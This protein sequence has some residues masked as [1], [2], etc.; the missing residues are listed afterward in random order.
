MQDLLGYVLTCKISKEFILDSD[1]SDE[2]FTL[3]FTKDEEYDSNFKV[4]I[5]GIDSEGNLYKNVE[6]ADRAFKHI[7][8][9]NWKVIKK[10]KI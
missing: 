9:G 4:E 8:F 3:I 6:D 1:Y 10:E 5:T 2:S 7:L